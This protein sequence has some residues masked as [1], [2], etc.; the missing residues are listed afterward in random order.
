M[1]R[2]SAQ[3]T[4]GTLAR[5]QREVGCESP[6]RCHLQPAGLADGWGSQ[7]MRRALLFVNAVQLGCAYHHVPIFAMNSN[8][9]AHGVGHREAE[10]FF[11]LSNVCG[12]LRAQAPSKSAPCTPV[13]PIVA[14]SHKQKE[15]CHQVAEC[16]VEAEA[17]ARNTSVAAGI[18]KWH[19][20]HAGKRTVC[21][22]PAL[23]P[24][25]VSLGPDENGRVPRTAWVKG[26][27]ALRRAFLLAQGGT[28]ALPWYR[29]H[30]LHIAVHIRRGDLVRAHRSRLMKATQLTALVNFVAEALH[31]YRRDVAAAHAVQPLQSPSA[32]S[33]SADSRGMGTRAG[34]SEVRSTTG[35]APVG[36]R[37]DRNEPDV[38]VHVITESCVS[39]HAQDPECA[40]LDWSRWRETLRRAANATLSEHVDTDPFVAMR[41][42]IGADALVTCNSGFSNMA[43]LYSAGVKVTWEP[44]P[45]AF[46][47]AVVWGRQ[48][49]YDLVLGNCTDCPSAAAELATRLREYSW[50]RRREPS[51]TRS[52]R[53]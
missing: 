10:A 29:A 8:S 23:N 30:G 35:G 48:W 51:S 2:S 28:L 39:S 46:G 16:V 15:R 12:T 33:P 45:A 13:F 47:T 34:R 22:D 25:R 6:S 3:A 32:D 21:A 24:P 50:H 49:G 53:P 43:V 31:Y 36:R 4:S 41:H 19:A 7:H 9:R 1:S 37:E 20:A 14:L 38:H 18:A 26:V 27:G 42:M 52:I 17:A 11:G 40:P 5:S 44:V